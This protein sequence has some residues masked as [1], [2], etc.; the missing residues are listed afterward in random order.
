MKSDSLLLAV[1]T[2]ATTITDCSNK[3]VD[4]RPLKITGVRKLS[5]IKRVS[6]SH[7]FAP[8]L[9]A[10][11]SIIRTYRLTPDLNMR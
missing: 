6:P 5:Q 7:G 8:F 9:L 11:S 10:Q 1:D 3:T 4:I 2:G